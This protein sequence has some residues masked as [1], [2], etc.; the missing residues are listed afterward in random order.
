MVSQRVGLEGVVV[1]LKELLD[2]FE[3]VDVFVVTGAHGQFGIVGLHLLPGL[4]L[5]QHSIIIY[6]KNGIKINCTSEPRGCECC[7]LLRC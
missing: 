3:F 1:L 6:V 5:G 2:E 4:D 7:A